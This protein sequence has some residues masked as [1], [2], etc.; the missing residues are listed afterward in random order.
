MVVL[1]HNNSRTMLR[2]YSFDADFR[3]RLSLGP[4]A[5]IKQAAPLGIVSRTRCST[6]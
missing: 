1:E 4:I 6:E 2:G 3:R 5:M